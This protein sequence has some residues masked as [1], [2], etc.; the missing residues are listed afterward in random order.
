MQFTSLI[1]KNFIL[2]KRGI[3]G[4]LCEQLTPLIFGIIL[5]W[6]YTMRVDVN[7]PATSYIND[8][9]A[10]YPTQ[11]NDQSFP[12]NHKDYISLLGSKENGSIRLMK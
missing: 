1:K 11:F 4:T 3:G 10:L 7:K 8:S 6:F 12:S 5:M 9:V 2:W